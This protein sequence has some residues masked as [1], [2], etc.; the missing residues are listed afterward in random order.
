[1]ALSAVFSG[2]KEVRAAISEARDEKRR[3]HRTTLFIDEIHRFNK[4][5]QDALLPAVEDGTVTLI[6]ATTEN[7]SFEVIGALLS[8]SRVLTLEPLSETDVVALLRRALGSAPN[9]AATRKNYREKDTAS[10]IPPRREYTGRT[11]TVV[12]LPEDASNRTCGFECAVSIAH[13]ISAPAAGRTN[14]WTA[15]PA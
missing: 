11:L 10:A 7:P 1:V 9:T 5:Q 15:S 13:P 14:V 4:A 2:V 12:L 3:G 8:R 6:G